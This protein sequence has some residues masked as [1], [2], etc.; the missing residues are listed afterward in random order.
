MSKTLSLN[1]R[2]HLFIKDEKLYIKLQKPN[3]HNPVAN[4]FYILKS[5]PMD[6]L[7]KIR[8][9]ADQ[10]MEGYQSDPSNAKTNYI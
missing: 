7:I 10:V 5:L 6:D 2:T 9:W 8:N 4:D 1:R 3:T